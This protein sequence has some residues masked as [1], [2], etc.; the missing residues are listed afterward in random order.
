M[1][2]IC[3]I[4]PLYNEEKYLY[5]TITALGKI[6]LIDKIVV[7]DD[8]STDNT[9]DI[10]SSMEGIIKLKNGRNMGKSASLY[11]GVKS[12]DADIYAFLD[13]DLGESASKVEEMIQQV[14]KENLDMS[15]ANIPETA[16]SG[17]M[18]LLRKFSRFS[19]KFFTGIDF[20]CP[21]SGQR[22]IRKSVLTNERVKFH[23]GFGI[24]TGML[25]DA[26]RCGYKIGY[27]HINF[28]HRITKGDIKGYIH[29]SIQFK[30]VLL[31]FLRELM[32]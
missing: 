22:V 25:I 24:E 11:N 18:G 29:R 2:K 1:P 32:R 31:V 30:D 12:I 5:A 13:G 8:G 4:I 17:G 6:D 16:G 9:W 3:A 26:I 19:V 23:S 28:R 10:I 21:L 27:I 20:P 7:I 14:I 15:I